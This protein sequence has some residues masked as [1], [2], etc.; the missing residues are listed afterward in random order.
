MA[1]KHEIDRGR[2]VSRF[3]GTCAYASLIHVPGVTHLG[4][5]GGVSVVE[6]AGQASASMAAAAS[7]HA[8]V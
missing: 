4:I 5:C 1:V 8:I 2:V 7:V 6:G 3:F